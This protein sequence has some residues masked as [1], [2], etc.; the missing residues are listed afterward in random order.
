MSDYLRECQLVQLKILHAVDE[1]CRR[2]GLR[3]FLHGGTLLG[4]M[5]HNGFIPWDDDLDVGMPIADFRKFVRIA[6]KELPAGLALQEA[7]DAPHISIPFLKIRDTGTFYCEVGQHM[8]ASDPS[9]IYID[10]FPFEKMPKAP[11]SVQHVLMRMISSPWMRQRW[12]LAKASDHVLLSPLF[13]LAAIACWAAHGIGRLVFSAIRMVLPC[14]DYFLILE[15]GDPCPFK[16]AWFEPFSKHVFEDAEF[17]IPADADACLRA[18]YGD[19]HKVPP[20]EERPSHARIVDPFR[21][22]M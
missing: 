12:L 8:L 17:S 7:G 15:K 22:A 5:R 11:L 16:I 3:Y 1:I 19:W 14:E 20:P 6:R 2:H 13:S 10:V 4:A 21:A 9:G 18:S